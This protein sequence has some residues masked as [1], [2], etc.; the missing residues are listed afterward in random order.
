MSV[1]LF[2][3][4]METL[5]PTRMYGIDLGDYQGDGSRV[6]RL[7]REDALISGDGQS[8]IFTWREKSHRKVISI[9]ILVWPSPLI[10]VVPCTGLLVYLDNFPSI[11]CVCC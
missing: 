1:A 3:F 7:V 5:H 2:I 9:I 11:L 4:L 6:K 10:V 8:G